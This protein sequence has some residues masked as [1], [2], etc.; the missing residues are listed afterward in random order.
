MKLL[1]LLV[2]TFHL[3]KGIRILTSHSQTTPHLEHDNANVIYNYCDT[4]WHETSD[5]CYLYIVND[6]NTT[7]TVTSADDECSVRNAH[8]ISVNSYNE[9]AAV[10]QHLRQYVRV[11]VY[12]NTISKL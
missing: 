5:A 1:F 7:V 3:S 10:A 9:R 11:C 6:S 8:L 4:G 2:A 12:T